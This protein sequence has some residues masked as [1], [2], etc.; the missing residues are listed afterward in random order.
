ALR[1]GGN[2]FAGNQTIAGNVGI[3]TVNPGAKLE[4]AG[5]GGTSVRVTGPGGSGTTVALDLATYDPGAGNG[6]SVRIQATDDSYSGTLDFLTKQPGAANNPMRLRLQLNL[7]GH[8]N[9]DPAS[10]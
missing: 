3:G 8:V 7:D 5:P 2:A 6:P 1:N 4:V 9:I 10:A